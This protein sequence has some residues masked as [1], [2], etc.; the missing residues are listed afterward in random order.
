[1]KQID[2]VKA[3]L[4]SAKIAE[5]QTGIDA[6]FSL[7]QA[8]LESGWGEKSSGEF[9]IFGIK[10]YNDP[11][12]AHS[13]L[14]PTIEFNASAHLTPAQIGLDSIDSIVPS[15]S[16]PGLWVY[17]GKA[18]FAKYDSTEDAFIKHARLFFA[19]QANG[20]QPYANALQ[21]VGKDV[22]A[23][24]NAIAPVYASGPQY[25]SLIISIMHS[26]QIVIQTYTL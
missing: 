8:A 7:A 1:M 23:F 19:H 22:N 4:P 12:H 26:L 2:F 17:H 5:A 24:I 9:N 25:A 18:W 3:Y 11:T 21:F 20:F 6:V 14:V 16:H 15:Q 13:Q 10:S